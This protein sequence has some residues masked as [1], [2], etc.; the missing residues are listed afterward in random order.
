MISGADILD[1]YCGVGVF[2]LCALSNADPSF[3][4][5][6]TGVESGREAI[7]FAQKNAKALKLDAS[8]YAEEVVRVLKKIEISDRTTIIADPP[9]GGMEPGVALHLAK[10]RAPRIFYVSCDPATLTRDLKV[11]CASY[12]VES[13]RLFNMF[14][15]TARFETLVVLKKR[16]R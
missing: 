12:E 3:S 16:L 5:R 14:P 1:L 2:G 13:V 11:I 4:P 9:R 8:F 7:L 10:S 15:R 6:L